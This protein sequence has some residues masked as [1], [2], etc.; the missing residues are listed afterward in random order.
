MINKKAELTTQQLVTIIILIVSFTVILFLIFRL[1]L[2][3]T[4]DKQICH[5]SVVMKDKAVGF[6]GALNC[7]TQYVCISGGG[8]CEGITPTI[9]KEVDAESQDEIMQAIAEEM[10]DCWWMFG[11]GE[12]EYVSGYSE[13]NCAICSIVKFDGEIQS[14]Q[15]APLT[16]DKIYDYLKKTKKSEGISYLKYLY[17]ADDISSLSENYFG[18]GAISFD[19]K[20]SIVTG[21]NNDAELLGFTDD[22]IRSSF[23]LSDEVKAKTK[24]D[25]FEITKA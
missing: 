8:E 25:V 19:K 12:L 4:T 24:C 2:G 23:I 6:G 14:K 3:E 16:Q 9:I 21:L 5:N 10:V 15:T 7:K 13:F 18:G 22:H 20:Y 1:N 11:E 17:D